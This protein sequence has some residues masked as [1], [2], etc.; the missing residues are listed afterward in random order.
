MTFHRQSSYIRD[1]LLGELEDAVG[2]E[3][4]VHGPDALV[5]YSVDEF[6]VPRM[7][8]D[9]GAIG[10]LPDVVVLPHTTDEVSAVLRI[11]RAYRLPVVP[12][13]GGSGSQGGALSIH[14]GI[15][16]DLKRLN[17]V[18]SIDEKSLTATAQAGILHEHLEWKLNERNLTL[19]HYP[20]SSYCATLGGSIAHR[21]S[22]V[23][24]TKYGKL[25]SMILS[26]QVVL[27]DGRVIHTLPVPSHSSGPGLKDLFV[28]S[29]GLLG[30]VTEA[31]VQIERQPETRLF[32]ACLFPDL[33]A[34]LEAGRRIMTARLRPT[35]IRLYDEA[36]TVKVV[37]RVL[38]IDAAGA[39]MVL[40]FDGFDD[41][42]RLEEKHALAICVSLGA[43]DLGPEPGQEW[44]EH[45]FDFY[46]PSHVLRLPQLFGTMDTLTTYD[47]I[48]ALYREK[49]RTLESEFAQ[50]NTQY[51]AHFSHWYP[52][53]VMVY[54]RFII[55][56]P[57]ADR[58]EALRL[59]NR[60]WNAGVRASLRMG[61]VINE[62]HGIGLKLGR[63]M[64][65]QYGEAFQ[66]L[67]SIKDALDPLRLL[68]PGKTGFPAGP[69]GLAKEG[70]PDEA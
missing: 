62:H 12:W 69:C 29:E 26:L 61:G 21:G 63:F 19:P 57:P 67:E 39:Y 48:E 68:N 59:H 25:E 30:I 9:S 27:A 18:L 15:V 1:M 41:I 8:F 49:K 28:G 36:S 53:G 4:V 33:G 65:E 54:D 10:P 58:H 42:C 37:K 35:V 7:W 17:R 32:R 44:W 16:I 55:D 64:R 23:F 51:I 24:S 47:K 3:W 22:G 40:G 31:T 2:A 38:G 13:G 11:A 60:V 56:K 46:Y 45:R 66:V 20:A 34:G 14:G 5:P 52:W 70:D 43:R 6:W 50:W